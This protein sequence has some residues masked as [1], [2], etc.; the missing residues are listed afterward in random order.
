MMRLREEG[1]P[2]AER[3]QKVDL[4]CIAVGQVVNSKEKFSKEIKS[5][6]SVSTWMIIQGICL[7][8]DEERVWV[9]WMEASH[10]IPL[11]PDLI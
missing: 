10:S 9:V 1:M 11:S 4:F 8:A 2:K 5:T 3:G 7:I 6:T